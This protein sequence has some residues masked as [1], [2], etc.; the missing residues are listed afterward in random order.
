MHAKT[1]YAYIV[2]VQLNIGFTSFEYLGALFDSVTPFFWV[3][4]I[5][6]CMHSI[7]AGILPHVVQTI[8]PCMIQPEAAGICKGSLLK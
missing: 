4:D 3:S 2:V 8:G 6:H 5:L 1:V 7:R